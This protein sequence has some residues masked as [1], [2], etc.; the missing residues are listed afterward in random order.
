MKETTRNES[1]KS[2][3]D[4]DL[5]QRLATRFA[6]GFIPHR[7]IVTQLDFSRVSEAFAF[8]QNGYRSEDTILQYLPAF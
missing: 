5:L 7:T 8:C 1:D 6:R 2:I 3:V 4:G